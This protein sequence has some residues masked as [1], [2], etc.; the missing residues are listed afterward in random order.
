[1]RSAVAAANSAYDSMTKAA[2]QV[3]DLAEANVSAA[4]DATVKA[5]STA[6]RKVA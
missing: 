1:M 5:V 2:R 3:T 4:T 6:S